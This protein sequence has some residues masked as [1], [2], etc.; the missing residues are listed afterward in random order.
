MKDDK[1]KKV[2]K[3]LDKDIKEAKKS[4]SEDKEL[5]KKMKGKC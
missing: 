4:I 1:K 3:H 5:K 2:K